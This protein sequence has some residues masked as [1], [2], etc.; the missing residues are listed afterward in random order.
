MNKEPKS[1]F[2][3]FVIFMLQ[4]IFFVHLHT[5]LKK[6]KTDGKHNDKYG[7]NNCKKA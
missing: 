2:L 3:S 1:T 7:Y 5:S 6:S 4:N